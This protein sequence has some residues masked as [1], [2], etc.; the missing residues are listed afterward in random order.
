[1]DGD[2]WMNN[3]EMKRE[4]KKM[5]SR[6]RIRYKSKSKSESESE[7]ESESKII[8]N[9]YRKYVFRKYVCIEEKENRIDSSMIIMS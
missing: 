8:L 3:I 5:K 7:S 1:M 4:M 6:I 2:I 9:M